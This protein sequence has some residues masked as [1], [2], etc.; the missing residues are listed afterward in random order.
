MRWHAGKKGSWSFM[1]GRRVRFE[2]IKKSRAGD[3]EIFLKGVSRTEFFQIKKLCAIHGTSW[4][5]IPAWLLKRP[6]NQI[7]SYLTRQENTKGPKAGQ[8]ETSMEHLL[9]TKGKS[10][11]T[12]Y[13]RAMGQEAR[14]EKLKKLFEAKRAIEVAEKSGKRKYAGEKAIVEAGIEVLTALAKKQTLE[15]EKLL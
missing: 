10:G 8:K 14:V 7:E 4:E 13:F 12:A 11:L 1:A 5:K 2:P 3:E 15:K 6:L 9:L